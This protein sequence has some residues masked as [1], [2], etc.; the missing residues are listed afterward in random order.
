MLTR[1][2]HGL[3]VVALD[4][5]LGRRVLLNKFDASAEYGSKHVDLRR[6]AGTTE[7]WRRAVTDIVDFHLDGPVPV[8]TYA[9][10][11]ALLERRMWM[12]R[13]AQVTYVEWRLRD[14]SGPIELCLKALLTIAIITRS[15][16]HTTSRASRRSKASLQRCAWGR[17]ELVPA[18]K[19][20]HLEP[21]NEWY[22]GF[23]YDAEIARGLDAIEDLYHALTIRASCPRPGATL[24]VRVALDPRDA[25][26]PTRM[27]TNAHLLDLWR[28]CA[29]TLTKRPAWIEQLVLAADAFIVAR[30]VDGTPARR[31]SPAI[32]GSAIGGATR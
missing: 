16:V 27:S 25:V 5:P 32:I 21:A 31:S 18:R 7:R 17:D 22:Y 15:R 29:P 20:W 13:D 28:Q 12:E 9:F 2:Y 3:F 14:A 10:A 26:P 6:I 11:D 1:R 8:W 24:F 30:E 4:P 19:R 23:R